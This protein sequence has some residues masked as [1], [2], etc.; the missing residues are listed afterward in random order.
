VTPK[1]C[2]R[3]VWIS[4]TNKTYSRLKNTASTCKKSHAKIPAA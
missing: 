1:M 2:T 3:R 4:M